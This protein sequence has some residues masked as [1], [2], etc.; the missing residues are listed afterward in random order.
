M[1]LALRIAVALVGLFNVAMG[2]AFLVS[3]ARMIAGFALEPIGIQG[4][5]TV[6]ADMTAFFLVGGAFALEGAWHARA[7]PLR[8]PLALL[9]IAFFGRCVGVAID[10]VGPAT[11]APMIAEA[12]MLAVL[13]TAY[14]RLPGH[15]RGR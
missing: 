14:A 11:F 4:L 8:V 10:G 7:A 13:A 5:A 1:I 6:R 2:V 3:P 15:A 9:G 12:V